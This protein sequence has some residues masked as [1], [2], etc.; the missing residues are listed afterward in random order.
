M[1]FAH[2]TV[3]VIECLVQY[4][5]D[6]HREGVFEELKEDLVDMSKEK[7]ARFLLKKMLAYGSKEQ[8]DAVITAFTGRVTKLIK[9]SVS[10]F[11]FKL[12]FFYLSRKKSFKNNLNHNS[13]YKII[14][15]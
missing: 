12:E 4:G 5:T 9:H 1:S 13:K 11:Y 15:F 10:K 7:Y 2:D 3:R 6:K 8:K 14:H